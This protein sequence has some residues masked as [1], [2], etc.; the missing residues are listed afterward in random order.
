MFIRDQLTNVHAYSPGEQLVAAYFLDQGEELAHKSARG[1]A[2]D[3]YL[4]APSVVRFC[5]KLGFAG[6]PE[7]RDAYLEELA[8]LSSHFQDIDPNEPF[9]GT[10]DIMVVAHK[11]ASLHSEALS[12]TQSMLQRAPFRRAVNLLLAAETVVICA[13]GSKYHLACIFQSRMGTIG[14]QVIVD[15]DGF[16]TYMRACHDAKRKTCYLFISYS[17]ESAFC[18]RVA[19][20]VAER[21]L[22]AFAITSRGGNTLSR[23]IPCTLF[24][25]TRDRLRSNVAGFTSATSISYL[26]DCLYAAVF[27]VRHAENLYARS[28]F[29]AGFEEQR[30]SD[31]PILTG[32]SIDVEV[33][34]EPDTR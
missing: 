20:K 9:A 11:L 10:D 22:P 1:I 29:A 28:T 8:Y 7:F 2:A 30:I 23:L 32:R 25:T 19:R 13:F 15:Q 34:G 3:L 33:D 18:L 16:D 26:L 4:S 24:T 12:D 14:R 21:G 6:Y 31:N 27:N 5:Q 17:G